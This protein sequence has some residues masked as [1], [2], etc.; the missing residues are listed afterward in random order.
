MYPAVDVPGGAVVDAT[1]AGDAFRAAFAVSLAESDGEPT[2][3]AARA[4]TAGALA[5]ATAGATPSLPTRE[6]VC[7]LL[8]SEIRAEA[9]LGVRGGRE[10]G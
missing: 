9:G 2:R 6:A 8:P 1:A 3:E 4:A 7:A 5:C 10:H